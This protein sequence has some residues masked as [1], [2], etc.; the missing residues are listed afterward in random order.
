MPTPEP[1]YRK[2]EYLSYSTLLSFARCPRRYEYQKRG[3]Y[4]NEESNALLYGTAMHKAVDLALREGLPTA[5]QAFDSVWDNQFADN[6]RSTQRA[7]AQLAH[8]VHTHEKGKSIFVPEAPPQSTVKTTEDVSP[9]EIPFAIDIGLD[10]P[11][12]GRLDGW[13]RHR[14][15]GEYWGREFKTTSRISSGLFNGLELNPQLL[16]YALVLRSLAGK[17]IRGI[18][19]EAMLVDPVKVD[20]MTHPVL[21][22]DHQIDEIHTWLRYFGELLLACEAR[23]EFPKNFS[24]CSSYPHF[25]TPGSHCEYETLCKIPRWQDMA[26]WYT[27]KEEHKMV[28]LTSSVVVKT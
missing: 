9:Y 15:T 18:M 14:D 2:R 23:G 28:E 10:I 5:T 22:Q 27:V 6:K 20:N 24:G 16:T 7:H 25:Y 1:P 17:D 3:I 21:I 19:F 13:C 8:Y 12:T 11:L 4:P 26:H